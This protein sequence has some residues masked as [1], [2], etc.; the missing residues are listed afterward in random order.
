MISASTPFTSPKPTPFT[1][2]ASP[3]TSS[4]KEL[5][6]ALRL[7]TFPMNSAGSFSSRHW[8]T[9]RT[10]YSGGCL[11]HYIPICTLIPGQNPSAKEKCPA[12][13]HNSGTKYIQ[14]KIVPPGTTIPGQNPSQKKNVT[15]A[16]I[17]GQ[18]PSQRKIVPLA[19]QFRDKIHRN[20]KMSRLAP[21]NRTKKKGQ[22][23]PAAQSQYK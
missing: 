12:W 2:A 1:C 8:G 21:Q 18:N 22:P 19:P 10:V 6:L 13:R 7:T 23:F 15:S 3:T 16:T 14:R 17:P 4:P 11:L 9:R 20:E 5:T